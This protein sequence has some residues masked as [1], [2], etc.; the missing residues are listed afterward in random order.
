MDIDEAQGYLDNHDH[1]MAKLHLKKIKRRKWDSLSPQQK[2]RVEAAFASVLLAEGKQAEACGS[3][4]KRSKS[5]RT[6]N[7]PR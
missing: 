4:S 5:S 7:V 6:L 1:Q 3:F 2:Y